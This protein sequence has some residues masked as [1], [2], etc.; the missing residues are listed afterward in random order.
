MVA[1]QQIISA[2]LWPDTAPS[3]V[4]QGPEHEPKL[5]LYRPDTTDT[6]PCVIICPGGGYN[7]LSIHEGEPV[8]RW[9]A[10]IG[11]QSCAGRAKIDEP[12]T[13]P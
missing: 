6:V 12:L 5:A 1:T 13:V 4:G 3:A 2:P 11:T 8:A 10:H 9:F 7:H